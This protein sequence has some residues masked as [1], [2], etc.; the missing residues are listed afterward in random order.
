MK[1]GTDSVVLGAWAPI[2]HNPFS[3]LDIGAG[4]GVLS[5]MLAQRSQAQVIEALEID[6]NAYEQCVDNFEQSQW[7]DRLFCFHASLEEF[8]E[9]IEDTYDLIICNPP[10]YSENYK[11]ENRQRDLARFQ[12]A[13]PFEHLLESIASLLSKNGLFSVIIPYSEEH[14]FITT[15]NQFELYCK[16]ITHIKGT[17]ISKIKRS[18][19]T[20]SFT[21]QEVLTTELI[22]ETSRHKYTHD[23]INLTKDFYLKM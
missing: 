23:Y 10:F 1:I 9:E 21:T 5:L 22:I 2:K 11:T 20:F 4:T 15:A 14:K 19:L 12:D 18:L 3:I 6:D 8:V 16:E 13:M 7:N 17:P